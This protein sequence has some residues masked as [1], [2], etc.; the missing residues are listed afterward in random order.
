MPFSENFMWGG[1]T[2][3]NQYEGGYQEG[4]MQ[5]PSCGHVFTKGALSTGAHSLSH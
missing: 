4:G 2:A 3:A 5:S 1:A